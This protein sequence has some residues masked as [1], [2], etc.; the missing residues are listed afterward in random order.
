MASPMSAPFNYGRTGGDVFR[1]SAGLTA[2]TVVETVGLQGTVVEDAV[3][4]SLH[5]MRTSA[6]GDAAAN[7]VRVYTEGVHDLRETAHLLSFD[8]GAT[9]A[10]LETTCRKV[11]GDAEHSIILNK[12]EKW[13]PAV[14]PAVAEITTELQRLLSD[15]LL[16]AELLYFIGNSR[17]T[18]FGIHIDDAADA[19]HFNFGP[20]HRQIWLWEPERFIELTGGRR[21]FYRTQELAEY[22]QPNLVRSGEMFFLPATRY[23]H[24]AENHG[25]SISMVLTLIQYSPERVVR[26]AMRSRA[27]ELA[28][29]EQESGLVGSLL[30]QVQSGDFLQSR[31]A[32]GRSVDVADAV[33]DYVL[34]IRS[35]GG[36]RA[37]PRSIAVPDLAGEAV[38][39]V[40]PFPLILQQG[41]SGTV[42]IFARG[43]VITAPDRPGIRELVRSLSGNDS[44]DAGNR[45]TALET[46]SVLAELVRISAVEVI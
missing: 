18:P 11:F 23:Y 19:L 29:R 12:V 38:R 32:D 1:Q 5:A 44:V 41:R 6:D 22:G 10:E 42:K 25:F 39:R 26:R 36:F 17:F 45:D 8:P 35:N 4:G 21:S 24:V 20:S 37:T 27:A 43:A 14:A 9:L 46:M 40:R 7:D 16:H 31:P 33:A 13:F 28:P 34:R 3:L 30:G 15:S 2:A